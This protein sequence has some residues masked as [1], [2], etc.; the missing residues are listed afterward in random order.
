[1]SRNVGPK[2]FKVDFIGPIDSIDSITRIS[3]YFSLL[4]NKYMRK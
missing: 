3:H 1:M 4:P 2:L